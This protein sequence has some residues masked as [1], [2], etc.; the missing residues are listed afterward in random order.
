MISIRPQAKYRGM[1]GGVGDGFAALVIGDV[2]QVF[3]N[4]PL[5]RQVLSTRC[6]CL[7]AAKRKRP[8]R[9]RAWRSVSSS[10]IPGLKRKGGAE[11]DHPEAIGL[12][13][14]VR[15]ANLMFADTRMEMPARKPRQNFGAG[16]R[17]AKL[18]G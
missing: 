6:G 15:P 3:A 5:I 13:V 7:K 11:S 17:T 10:S 8:C 14:P 2:G 9:R 4:P 12:P 1:A 16:G 18:F